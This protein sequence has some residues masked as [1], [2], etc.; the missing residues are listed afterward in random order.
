MEVVDQDFF[1]VGIGSSAGGIQALEAFFSNIR[2]H[3]NAAFVVIQH[4]SPDFRSMMS[5]ILQRK[6]VMQVVQIEENMQIRPGMVYVMPPGKNILLQER[7][8]CL[9]DRHGSLNYPINLFFD[10]MAKSFADRAIGVVLT[11]GGSDGTEGLQR[12][13]RSGGV[14]LVQTPDSAQFSSMPTNAIASGIVDKVLPPDELAQAVY[15]IV[16]FSYEQIDTIRENEDFV[17]NVAL[18]EI[19]QLLAD[20]ESIDFT[21]YKTNTLRR[22]IRHRCVLN[23]CESITSY[24]TLLNDS[25]EERKTLHHSLL[26]GA[27]AF[28]RDK[29]PWPYLEKHVFPKIIE[30]LDPDEQLRVWVSAC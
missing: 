17:S 7:T 9:I 8:F 3:P 14:A 6:T 15:N 29:D 4:L 10:S 11:G 25:A 23:S 24:I 26:I 2:D 27:T 19:I 12:L 1:V 18:E 22:R 13:S 28:F 20:Q 21:D 30:Q 16:R 5:E